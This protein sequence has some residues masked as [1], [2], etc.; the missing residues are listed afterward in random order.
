ML[1]LITDYF[2]D[3][4]WKRFDIPELWSHIAWV[5]SHRVL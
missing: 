5:A 4:I 2:R 3:H 1:T